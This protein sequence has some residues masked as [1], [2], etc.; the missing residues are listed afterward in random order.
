MYEYALPAAVAV[1]RLSGCPP[2]KQEFR[3][4]EP[5]CPPAKYQ[6]IRLTPDGSEIPC[7]ARTPLQGELILG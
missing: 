6:G 7:R 1:S 2:H 5:P 3:S 4:D